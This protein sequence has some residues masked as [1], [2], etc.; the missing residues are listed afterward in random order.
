M[1]AGVVLLALAGCSGSGP[2][3]G[4]PPARPS[5]SAASASTGRPAA[6]SASPSATGAQPGAVPEPAH[7]VVVV[8]EN[9]SYAE[10]MGNPAAPFINTLARHGALFTRSYAITHP[11]PA[12]LP[13][14]VLR[15]HPGDYR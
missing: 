13:G 2:A 14:A 7:T 4:G 8:M 5:A 9:H 1:F 11:E 12:E 3:P 6:G 10:I 15:Q